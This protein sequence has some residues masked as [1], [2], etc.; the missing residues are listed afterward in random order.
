[1]Y[2]TSNTRAEAVGSWWSKEESMGKIENLI[3]LNLKAL[4]KGS[5][6]QPN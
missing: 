1:M 6:P 3:R 2:F 5:D 4:F